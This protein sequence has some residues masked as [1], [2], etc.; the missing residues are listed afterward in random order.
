MGHGCWPGGVSY[1][2]AGR[3]DGRVFP[4]RGSKDAEWKMLSDRLISC[5]FII[6]QESV[7]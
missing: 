1:I 3:G 7:S 2:S 6:D 5:F 4:L